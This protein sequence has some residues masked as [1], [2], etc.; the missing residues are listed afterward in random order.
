[1]VLLV[2]VHTVVLLERVHS[3]MTSACVHTVV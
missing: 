3:G 2:R 1:M